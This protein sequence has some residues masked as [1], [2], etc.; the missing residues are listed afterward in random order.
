MVFIIL[1]QL[2]E[3]I[4]IPPAAVTACPFCVT[5]KTL[6]THKNSSS[7]TWTWCESWLQ[8]VNMGCQHAA[9]MQKPTQGYA[10]EHTLYAFRW[11]LKGGTEWQSPDS[12]SALC[13]VYAVSFVCVGTEVVVNITTYHLPLKQWL[14]KN[15]F[16]F[17]YMLLCWN[18]PD[19]NDYVE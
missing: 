4:C 12:P 5:S 13:N 18:R 8:E 3:F 9:L 1:M 14:H 19:F 15:F 6:P 2:H 11:S 10:Q 17:A 7:S 16:P